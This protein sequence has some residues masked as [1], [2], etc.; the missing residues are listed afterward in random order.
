MFTF[1]LNVLF[2]LNCLK[3]TLSRV[4][5]SPGFPPGAEFSE[6]QSHHSGPRGENCSGVSLELR[7][8]GIPLRTPH[9]AEQPPRKRRSGE[10]RLSGVLEARSS[11]I[12]L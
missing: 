6:E 9:S 11:N 8:G 2:T 12:P 7:P 1:N 10:E 5:F 3:M 4:R